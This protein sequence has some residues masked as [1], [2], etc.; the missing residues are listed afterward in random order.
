MNI[1]YKTHIENEG[2]NVFV[3]DG[4]TSGTEG[5]GLRMEALVLKLLD[6]AG[7]DIRIEAQAHVQNQ[8]WCGRKNQS[9][10]KRERSHYRRAGDGGEW[11]HHGDEHGD[12]CGWN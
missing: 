5:K 7:L 2:W 1:S 11:E 9:G 8:G 4:A 3:Q 6:K 10:R 12:K